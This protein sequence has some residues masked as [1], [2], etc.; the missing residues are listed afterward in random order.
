[1]EIYSSPVMHW[2][3]QAPRHTFHFRLSLSLLL[4][5]LF[6]MIINCRAQILSNDVILFF[7]EPIFPFFFEGPA[8]QWRLPSSSNIHSASSH[9]S[10]FVCNFKWIS[11]NLIK[12]IFKMSFSSCPLSLAKKSKVKCSLQVGFWRKTSSLEAKRF[13]YK[14]ISHPFLRGL[15]IEYQTYENSVSYVFYTLA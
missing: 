13:I 10:I 12:T 11:I 5:S 7:V 6:S 8:F 14:C 2:H 15:L 4:Q 3:H 1:M 9:L